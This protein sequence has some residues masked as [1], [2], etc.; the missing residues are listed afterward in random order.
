[1]SHRAVQFNFENKIGPLTT[2]I[3]HTS[4]KP[5]T[6][7]FHTPTHH[8]TS[9]LATSSPPFTGNLTFLFSPN[10]F[11]LLFLNHRFSMSQF[12]GIGIYSFLLVCFYTFLGL[13]LGNRIAE[14]TL[15][16]IFS[17]M[18]DYLFIFLFFSSNLCALQYTSNDNFLFYIGNFGYVSVC[19]V[20]CD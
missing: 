1:M 8:E 17:F 15:T 14:I 18:V 12:V 13:F 4:H 19:E 2:F 7:H 10:S 20:Y 9:W 3:N 5:P 6:F 16:F 11:F